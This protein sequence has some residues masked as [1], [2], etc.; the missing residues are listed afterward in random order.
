MSNKKENVSSSAIKTGLGNFV[1]RLS[2][3]LRDIL[4]AQYFGTNANISAFLTALT[5]P[6]LSRRIFGEGALTASFIPL[7]SDKLDDKDEANSF[8]SNILSITFLT[9]TALTVLAIVIAAGLAFFSEG[10]LKEISYL[11]AFLMPYMIFICL[12]ALISGILNLK[13]SF[14]LPAISS[15]FFNLFLIAGCIIA[16]Y[17]YKEGNSNKIFILVIA[18]ILSG[19]TQLIFLATALKK[20]GLKLN[21]SPSFK[22]PAWQSVKKLFIPAIIGASVTQLSVLSDRVIANFINDYAVSALYYAERLTYFPVGIFGV[23]LGVACLPFMS[24]AISENNEVELM[25]SFKFAIRQTLFLT[26]PCSL[27]FYFYH[28]DILKVIFMRGEFNAE[29]LKQSSLALVYYLPGIPAF[30]ATK[31][32]LPLYYASKDTKTPVKVAIICLTLNIIIGVSLIPF[33][34]HASLAL[35]TTVAS[36]INCILLVKLS[37]QRNIKDQFLKIIIPL[38]RI[39]FSCLTSCIIVYCLPW[40][41]QNNNTFFMLGM[42]LDLKVIL[43]YL[44]FLGIHGLLGGKELIEIFKRQN[45]T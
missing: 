6:N 35:A 33:L 29:S 44:L 25:S 7:L 22:N 10:N 40:S 43:S 38:S 26:L 20:N 11:T 2:G 1:S 42:F 21:W 13:K 19:I 12:S 31:V 37:P 30:A 45:F 39:F 23:A 5:F 4:F 17:I 14:T 15:V 16:P 8:A 9:T 3:L 32:I 34:G 27:L 24:R 41:E 18:V 28:I 36:Y